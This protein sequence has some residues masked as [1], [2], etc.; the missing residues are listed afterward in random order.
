MKRHR[1][2]KPDDRPSGFTSPPH[3]ADGPAT[4]LGSEGPL[5]S[6][7]QPEDPLNL[8]VALREWPDIE[9]RVRSMA[10]EVS[11]LFGAASASVALLDVEGAVLGVVETS[12][13][14]AAGPETSRAE[15]NG[16][17]DLKLAFDVGGRVSGEIQ[18]RR[19]QRP[20]M[21]DDDAVRTV[22]AVSLAA[23]PRNTVGECLGV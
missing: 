4:G 6:D 17:R 16:P 21:A 23:R 2:Q 7:G 20:D 18:L 9:A 19:C 12:S 5:L 13:N 3:R 8:E 14:A 1:S 22:V 15:S 11:N 10:A